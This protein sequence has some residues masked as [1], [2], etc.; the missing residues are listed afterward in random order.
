MGNSVLDKAA[1]E[2]GARHSVSICFSDLFDK[3]EYPGQMT[4]V[5]SIPRTLYIASVYMYLL[6]FNTHVL[7]LW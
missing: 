4:F 7:K 3:R 6:N 2:H 1:Q 5:F